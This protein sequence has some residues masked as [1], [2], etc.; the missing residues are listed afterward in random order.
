[1][2]HLTALATLVTMAMAL[3][4]LPITSVQITARTAKLTQL[5]ATLKEL[6]LAPATVVTAATESIAPMMMNIQLLPT[7]AYS[8]LLAL[9][10]TIHLR[11]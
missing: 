2:I 4:A 9:K 5:V 1:M 6:L 10:Q 11:L 7:T 8:M 3:H